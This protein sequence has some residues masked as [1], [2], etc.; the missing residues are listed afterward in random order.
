MTCWTHKSKD[1]ALVVWR[2]TR[3]LVIFVIGVTVLLLGVA[4]LVLPG[5]G[6]LVILVALAV[7]A[8]EFVWA[9]L[10]LK[11]VKA[12]ATNA[13]KAV[14][15]KDECEDQE[16]RIAGFRGWG[17]RTYGRCRRACLNAIAP[18]RPGYVDPES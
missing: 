13:A 16:P 18:F 14:A 15:G 10:L 6:L 7:L 5:P 1:A 4:M 8:T 11:R 9:R 12:S 2:N 3:R 17:R